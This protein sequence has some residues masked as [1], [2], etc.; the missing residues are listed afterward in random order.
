MAYSSDV[1]DFLKMT[2]GATADATA[3][4]W[5]L[6]F[7]QRKTNGMYQDLLVTSGQNCYST[8]TRLK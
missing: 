5:A 4:E 6:C 7:R 3:D 8:E 1:T 2:G